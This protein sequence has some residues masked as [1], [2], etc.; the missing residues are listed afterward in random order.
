M[1]IDEVQTDGISL[2]VSKLEIIDTYIDVIGARGIS[3][4]A[5]DSI[6][7][8]RSTF[9]AVI[10][11]ESFRF[12]SNKINIVYNEFKSLPS[13]LLRDVELTNDKKINFMNN[14]I[15]DVDLGGFI[16]NSRLDKINFVKNKIMCDCTPRKTSILK[17]KEV[18]PGLL[19][20]ETNFDA[21][22]EHNSCKNYNGIHLSEFKR[23]FLGRTLCNETD[24]KESQSSFTHSPDQDDFSTMRAANTDNGC[25]IKWNIVAILICIC[26]TKLF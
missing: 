6:D 13:F 23:K 14:L 12:K 2:Q 18:F 1:Q 19:N 24:T 8:I 26:V 7:I 21:I 11:P 4:F 9:G 15:H 17:V 10:S 25:A 5:N 20:N 22:I 3:V 16:L